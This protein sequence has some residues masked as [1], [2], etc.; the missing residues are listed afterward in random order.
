MK[1]TEFKTIEE[2]VKN[3]WINI[4]FFTRNKKFYFD[5]STSIVIG[6]IGFPPRNS[7]PSFNEAKKAVYNC[8]ITHHKDPKQQEILYQFKFIKDFGQLD[9]F[10]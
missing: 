6:G 3:N 1:Y 10:E 5:L 4:G 9:L 8:L 2:K 7:Y